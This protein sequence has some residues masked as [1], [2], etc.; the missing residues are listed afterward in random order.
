MLWEETSDLGDSVCSSPLSPC[1]SV[2]YATVLCGAPYAGQRAGGAAAFR[3]SESSQPLLEEER[4]QNLAPGEL[5]APGDV[6]AHQ[7][8]F[9]GEGAGSDAEWE[10][11]PMLRAL[12]DG[13][14]DSGLQPKTDSGLQPETD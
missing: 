6:I 8:F 5:G 4:Y 9:F 11:F 2:S 14:T 10:E 13:W 1:G 3:R 7:P 12:G